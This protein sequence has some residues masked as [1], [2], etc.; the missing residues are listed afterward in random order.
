MKCSF[1]GKEVRSDAKFCKYCG[2]NLSKKGSPE[3]E[4]EVTPKKDYGMKVGP[5]LDS[6]KK[7]DDGGKVKRSLSSQKTIII[8]IVIIAVLA[9]GFIYLLYSS[10]SSETR[11][12]TESNITENE[13]DTPSVSQTENQSEQSESMTEVPENSFSDNDAYSGTENSDDNLQ[14]NLYGEDS[15]LILQDGIYYNP[16][17][18]TDYSASLDPSEYYTYTEEGGYFTFSYPTT[19]YNRVYVRRSMSDQSQGQNNMLSVYMYGS[20]GSS[21]TFIKVENE[22]NFRELYISAHEGLY[23]AEDIKYDENNIFI[24]SGYEDSS[25]Q[26]AVYYLVRRYGN[27]MYIMQID[28]PYNGDKASEDYI[29]KSYVVENFYRMCGFGGSTY[30]ARTYSQFKSGDKGEQY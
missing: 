5:S 25:C 26:I 30:K 13:T 1:C 19:L 2:A 6:D 12:S 10:R 23:D 21:A 27:D 18:V 22:S 11:V 9:A 24:T 28:F 8:L 14:N 16:E 7:D 4:G 15:G 29:Q 3:S 20:D 17:T